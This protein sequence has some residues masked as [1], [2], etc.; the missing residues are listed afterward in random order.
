MIRS[1]GGVTL[2][3]GG[4]L[5]AETL[6]RAT[7]RAPMLI[8]ADGGADRALALSRTPEWAVGDFDSITDDARAAIGEG[9][10]I[11]IAEQ[12]STDFDKALRHIE[13]P[14]VIGVGFGG[15]RMDHAMAAM[16]VI[17]RRRVPPCVLLSTDD[18]IFRAPG[19][20]SLDLPDGARLSLFPMGPARGRSNGLRWPI[21]GIEFAPG[22]VIGTSN[23][24][25]GPARLEIEGQMLVF[26]DPAYLDAALSAITA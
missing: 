21:D 1:A 18:V 7:R 5:R 3:G 15:A 17:A 4:A 14:F 13:A 24:A 12:D 25:L 6:E 22:D 16:N 26:L 8:A 19:R 20:F 23:M 9:R 11:H 2:V 10:L